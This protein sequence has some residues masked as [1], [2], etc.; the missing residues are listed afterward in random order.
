MGLGPPQIGP[1]ITFIHS[2]SQPIKKIE[3]L[4]END[5]EKLKYN[6]SLYFHIQ[7]LSDDACLM[8]SP[9]D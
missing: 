4:Y 2:P 1:R 6:L 7:L 8:F 5:L 9:L 3:E